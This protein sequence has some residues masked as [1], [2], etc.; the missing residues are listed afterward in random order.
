MTPASF[1]LTRARRVR[2]SWGEEDGEG[3]REGGGEEAATNTAVA[4]KMSGGKGKGKIKEKTFV[5]GV[6]GVG[7]HDERDGRQ[8]GGGTGKKGPVGP[9]L[10]KS[11]SGQRHTP[12]RSPPDYLK[13]THLCLSSFVLFYCYHRNSERHIVFPSGMCIAVA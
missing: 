10:K 8:M 9:N 7:G 13:V 12:I 6:G 11:P 1:V 3:E 4:E 5:V 2:T